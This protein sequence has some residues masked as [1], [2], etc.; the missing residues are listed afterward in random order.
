MTFSDKQSETSSPADLNEQ[1]YLGNSSG[2]S[3]IISDRNMEIQEV[4]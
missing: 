3:K 2:R 1:K 4:R